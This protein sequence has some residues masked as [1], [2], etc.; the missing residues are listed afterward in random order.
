MRKIILASGSPRRKEL[1]EGLD[2]N[3][4]VRLK[5]EIQENFPSDIEAEVVPEYLSRVKASAYLEDLQSNEIV[6]TAD[7][8]V[9]CDGSILGKI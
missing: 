2:F 3:F 6:I 5:Q 4:E 8:V 7:T 1:L 9:I